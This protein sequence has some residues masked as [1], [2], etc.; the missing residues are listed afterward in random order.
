MQTEIGNLDWMGPQTKA[1]ALEKLHGIVNK[2]GY[3]DKWRDYSAL[4]ISA[5]TCS[6]TSLRADAF[7]AHRQLAKIGKPVDRGEWGMTPPTV[8]AYYDPQMNDMNFPAGVLQPPLF[9]A[10]LDDAPNYGD[11][12]GMIGHELTHGFDDEGRQFDAHGNLK[13]WW[14]EE[15][16]RVR[17]APAA[18]RAV[19]RL[20][21]RRRHP[22]QR[23]AHARREHRRSRRPDARLIGLEGA[24]RRDSTPPGVEGSR[25]TSASSSASRNGLREHPPRGTAP[26]GGHRP[27]LAGALPRQRRRRQHAGVHPRVR[28]QGRA[29]DGPGEAVPGSGDVRLSGRGLPRPLQRRAAPVRPALFQCK[30]SR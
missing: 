5:T 26:A 10:K 7:E 20:H 17:Q 16:R 2:I 24:R 30:D 28:L 9:D 18:S 8:N 6:A 3:P 23:Q 14:T 1:K 21:R 25:R 27:A 4:D 12:G 29:A 11:I 15:D 19:R 22:H 13:D